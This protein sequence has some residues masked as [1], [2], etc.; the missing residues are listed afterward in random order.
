MKTLGLLGGMSAEST[1]IYYRL[2]NEEVRRRLGGLHSAECLIASVDFAPIARLQSENRWD[3]AGALLAERARRLQDAGAEVLLLCTNTM[4]K[5]ADTITSAVSIPF[6]HI[7][8]PTGAAIRAQ[9]LTRVALLATRF[10]MEEAFYRE[11]LQ[12][13]FGLEILVPERDDRDEVHRIIYEELCQGRIEASSRDTYLRII[14]RLT[15]QG[16]Q[17][18]ILGCTEIGLLLKP[19]NLTLPLFDTCALHAHAAVDFALA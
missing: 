8:D 7:A 2:L 1:Q 16:A 5:V 12:T 6:L 4:H 15:A 14:D 3:E 18:V 13:Q 19:E 11:R 9:G 17:A 10:T